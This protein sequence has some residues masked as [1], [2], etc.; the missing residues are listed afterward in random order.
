MEVNSRNLQSTRRVLED[1]EQRVLVGA[2][3]RGARSATAEATECWRI[4][5]NVLWG[6]RTIA[7]LAVAGFGDSWR[8]EK[9]A[10]LARVRRAVPVRVEWHIQG[11][12]GE[13]YPRVNVVNTDCARGEGCAS[14]SRSKLR[15]HEDPSGPRT[16]GGTS[17]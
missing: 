8:N 11:K 3:R 14:V 13:K 7:M 2:G 6:A 5:P 17:G 9:E 12:R 10:A 4:D 1:W 16:Q 15:R